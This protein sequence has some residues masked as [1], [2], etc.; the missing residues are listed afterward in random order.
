MGTAAEHTQSRF[1]GGIVPLFQ[2]QVHEVRSI[3]VIDGDGVR[4][5]KQTI[6]EGRESLAKPHVLP[7]LRLSTCRRI[8][9]AA[10]LMVLNALTVGVT[11]SS[12]V[13]W[14]QIVVMISGGTRTVTWNEFTRYFAWTSTL[15]IP[16]SNSRA[17]KWV[18]CEEWESFKRGPPRESDQTVCASRRGI[19]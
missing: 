5:G 14:E 2:S 19:S 9:V 17:W 4:M 13:R 10:P 8:C 6:R 12:V 7:T 18:G 1:D 11:A 3:G 15:L 16:F